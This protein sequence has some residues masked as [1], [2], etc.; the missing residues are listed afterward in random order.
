MHRGRRVGVADVT[1]IT[2]PPGL[3]PH[4]DPIVEDLPNLTPLDYTSCSLRVINLQIFLSGIRCYKL[5]TATRLIGRGCKES[6]EN[7]TTQ[8]SLD[9][10][11][12]ACNPEPNNNAIPIYV[13]DSTD[14]LT[15]PSLSE[16]RESATGTLDITILNFDWYPNWVDFCAV[17][18]PFSLNLSGGAQGGGLILPSEKD[19]VVE[20]DL[21][22]TLSIGV[23]GTVLSNLTLRDQARA[24]FHDLP[25]FPNWPSLTNIEVENITN[26]LSSAQ[27]SELPALS[28][29]S[30]NVELN[31][32]EEVDLLISNYLQVAGGVTIRHPLS[33]SDSYK[34]KWPLQS[35][36]G[37]LRMSVVPGN[38]VIASSLES[39]GGQLIVNGSAG[40]SFDFSSL[41]TVG[42]LIMEN[43]GDSI[44]PGD[45]S[46]LEFADEIYWN[47]YINNTTPDILPSL[48]QVGTSVTIE[49]WNSDFNCSNFARQQ[50]NGTDNATLSESPGS[51]SHTAQTLTK[52]AWAGIGVSI[53]VVVIG[54]IS[55]AIWRTRKQR[56][57]RNTQ[58]SDM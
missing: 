10:Y 14:N 50:S 21:S 35:V 36:T 43:N 27:L 53:L 57:N 56:S 7:V 52:G 51:G 26:S 2:I 20:L 46:S 9:T 18:T 41:N 15:F 45:L 6:L 34:Y 19:L 8:K 22:S 3:V 1:L 13:G 28:E 31:K 24:A 5:H 11:L 37:Y 42:K 30:G 49:A 38:A 55:I 17:E 44:L 16:F 58:S 32:I 54:L 4:N 12:D 47:G 39:I 33:F 48:E 29:V 25:H 23:Y 40:S